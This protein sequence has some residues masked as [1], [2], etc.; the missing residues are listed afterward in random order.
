MKRWRRQGRLSLLNLLTTIPNLLLFNHTFNFLTFG[1]HFSNMLS[2]FHTHTQKLMQWFSLKASQINFACTS[3][4]N[5]VPGPISVVPCI[6]LDP[7][8][9]SFISTLCIW[10]FAP[11]S[12]IAVLNL[13]PH[14]WVPVY[15][16]FS[17]FK[18]LFFSLWETG[19]MVLQAVL[20]RFRV[21]PIYSRQLGQW[22][23]ERPPRNGAAW[24]CGS[25]DYNDGEG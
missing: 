24:A 8:N 4:T 20:R 9:D 2:L 12:E 22:T 5:S 13:K 15:N 23:N 3:L 16:V 19:S 18:W 21:L 1:F 11:F 17:F 7:L 25:R 14:H 10:F 6:M